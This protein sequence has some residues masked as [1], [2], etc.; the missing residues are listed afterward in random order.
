MPCLILFT[1]FDM[2]EPTS[3]DEDDLF[4]AQLAS[5][6]AQG[7]GG[8][9]GKEGGEEGEGKEQEKKKELEN[10]EEEE[11]EEKLE[12]DAAIAKRRADRKAYLN[13]M[14]R[15]MRFEEFYEPDNNVYVCVYVSQ[16]L[17]CTYIQAKTTHSPSIP[18][19]STPLYFLIYQ[20]SNMNIDTRT[21][22]EYTGRQ[23]TGECK[24]G[25]LKEAISP[26]S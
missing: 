25:H 23:R 4:E 6:K 26:D 20:P 12:D 18:F 24:I 15:K 1:T 19:H 8:D 10:G 3:E 17:S 14:R 5:A 11:D 22:S 9:E 21:R 2:I 13:R 16:Y 7:N